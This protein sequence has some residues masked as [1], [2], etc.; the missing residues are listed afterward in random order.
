MSSATHNNLGGVYYEA[1]RLEDAAAAFRA[2]LELSPQRY[3]TR[4]FLAQVLA[5]LGRDDEA[6]AEARAEPDDV[7]RLLALVVIHEIAGRAAEAEA[8]LREMTAKHAENY[9]VQVAEAYGARGQADAAFAWLERALA[10]GDSGL[11]HIK[12][13]PHFRR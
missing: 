11:V 2:S 5:R 1:D 9:P 10:Q 8:A 3:D 7:F 6:L 12:P 4:S 13:S